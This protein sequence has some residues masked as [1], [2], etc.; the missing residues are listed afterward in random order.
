MPGRNTC[1]D[2][3]CESEDCQTNNHGYRNARFAN[4]T[5]AKCARTVDRSNRV[6]TY[7]EH[8]INNS[9]YQKE[10]KRESEQEK[11]GSHDIPYRH[12]NSAKRSGTV[13]K[14]SYAFNLRGQRRKSEYEANPK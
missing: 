8:R 14:L 2:D 7:P 3:A 1:A 12:R 13:Y 6:L 4:R 11:K 9:P 5:I 10:D